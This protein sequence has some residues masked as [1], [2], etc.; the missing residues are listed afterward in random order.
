MLSQ[1]KYFIGLN[2]G[3]LTDHVTDLSIKEV[4]DVDDPDW[5][6]HLE[7]WE[8][9]GYGFCTPM[10]FENDHNDLLYELGDDIDPDEFIMP[11]RDGELEI[12]HNH[13]NLSKILE[14][15]CNGDVKFFSETLSEIS[16]SEFEAL[17]KTAN[18]PLIILCELEGPW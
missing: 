18:Q 4:F 2:S 14:L 6:E 13:P 3:S 7:D 1:C 9:K 5:D 15:A 8:E 16:F 17:L 11:G 12:Q 10:N